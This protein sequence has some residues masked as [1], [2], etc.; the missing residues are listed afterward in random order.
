MSSTELAVQILTCLLSHNSL[1]GHLQFGQ[2]Q[3]FLELARQLWL[4]I[5]PPSRARPIVL[6]KNIASFMSSVLEL[7][8]EIIQL[9]WHAYSDLAQALFNA[10]SEPSLDDNFKQHGHAEQLDCHTRYYHNYS[11]KDAETNPMARQEYYGPQIPEFIHVFESC[12]VERALCVFFET[13]LCLSHSTCQGIARVYNCALA[14]TSD[15]PSA[16][17]LKDELGGNLVLESFFLHAILRHKMKHGETLMLSHRGHQNHRLDEVLAQRNYVMVD[18]VSAGVHDGVTVRHVACSVH[19][20]TE[21]LLSQRDLY[22]HTHR[23]LIKV[24]CIR[25]CDASAEPGFRTCKDPLHR[26][27]QAAAEEKNTA[28]FQLHSRLRKAGISQVTMAGATSTLEAEDDESGEEHVQ[29]D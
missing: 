10:P 20:C 15:H 1:K 27:F 12:Y 9:T 4:E 2:I 25:R 8:P 21:A 17:R 3:R 29:D 14:Y 18:K 22:C 11:V 16:S 26:A 13:E 7:K 24:C 19:N 28:M 23:D 6:P 5:V